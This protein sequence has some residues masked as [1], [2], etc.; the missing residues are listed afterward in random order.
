MILESNSGLDSGG[1]W[2]AESMSAL[3][4]SILTHDSAS[5]FWSSDPNAEL[6][7]GLTFQI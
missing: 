7:V 5:S 3:T 1:F 6:A 2:Q 4:M